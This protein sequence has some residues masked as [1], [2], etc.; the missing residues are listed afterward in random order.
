MTVLVKMKLGQGKVYSKIKPIAELRYINHIYIVRATPGPFIPKVSYHCPPQFVSKNSLISAIYQFY[1]VLF[2][3][4]TK[5]PSLIHSFLLF[6]HGLLAFI[7]AK[8][9][10]R[11]AGISLIAGRVE[12]FMIKPRTGVLFDKSPPWY[13][14]VFIKLLNKCDY[15]TVTGSVT[16]RA[17]VS[18]GICHRKIFKL[19]Q[20]ICSGNLENKKPPIKFD[21]IAAG[22][23]TPVKRFDMLLRIISQVKLHYPHVRL[24]ILGCGG[25]KTRL[26]KLAAALKI[27]DNVE[28]LGHQKDTS[29]YFS[30]SKI[31]ILTSEREGFPAVFGEALAFG[32]P[33][34]VS[35]CGDILDHA[36]S[37]N[38]CFVIDSH[39]G[40]GE[41]VE[42]VLE[43]LENRSLHRSMSIK[44]KK[45]AKE[46]GLSNVTRDWDEIFKSMP[47]N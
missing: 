2:L 17:L 20:F 1:L 31:F 36:A 45:S 22:R 4:I 8:M 38:N 5:K 30:R 11:K 16:G 3:S 21:L 39:Q 13:G 18:F 7:A 10:R 6:P 14:R 25:Q 43:L 29:R 46:F 42:K 15:I 34:V 24:G 41:Y 26:T 19:H 35:N 33:S 23:L 37:G 28:F 44:A 32:L 9:T 47:S 27:E 12:L 40:A